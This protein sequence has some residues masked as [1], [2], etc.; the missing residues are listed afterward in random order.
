M[1]LLVCGGRSYGR[2]PDG[3]PPDQ[4]RS[5]AEVAARQSFLLRETL[6]VIH[7]ATPIAVVI[8]G[9]AA[10]AD[11]HAD[12][13]A[14]LKGISVEPYKANWRTHGAKAGPIRNQQMLDA[15][16]PDMV[17]AFP[18]GRGTAD[19]VKRAKAAGIRLMEVAQD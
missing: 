18:G 13:W 15:G 7:Q 11:A 19:M 9:A 5:H 2:V 3:C 4:I 16:K 14:R 10:G 17:V 6:D 8:H 12:S 1:R